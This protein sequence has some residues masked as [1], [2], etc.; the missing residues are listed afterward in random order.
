MQ[1]RR[2]GRNQ[3]KRKKRETGIEPAT[4]SLGSWQSLHAPTPCELNAQPQY[5]SSDFTFKIH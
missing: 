1:N 5:S 4:S 2:S 3:L